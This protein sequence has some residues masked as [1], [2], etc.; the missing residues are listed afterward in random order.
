MNIFES[1]EDYLERILMLQNRSINVRAIDIANDMNFSRPS[2][3]IALKKLKEK[4]LISVDT[5][6]QVITF[7][8]EG[9][10]IAKTIYER[11]NVLSQ[12]LIALGV[13]EE[14]ALKDACEIE[15]V[16]SEES[17]QR[18]KEYMNRLKKD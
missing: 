2:V 12:C 11:H 14:N 9:L 8:K 1:A 13:S 15:H 3:S 16:I 17:F 18:L 7:T 6:T 10:K 5:T 4:N